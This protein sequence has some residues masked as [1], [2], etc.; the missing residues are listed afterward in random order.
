LATGDT[1]APVKIAARYR[2]ILDAPRG[3]C[4]ARVREVCSELGKSKNTI[5][6]H[7][8]RIA[9]G[10]VT[11]EGLPILRKPGPP[12][13]YG[14]KVTNWMEERILDEWRKTQ[15]KKSCYR[16][17]MAEFARRGDPSPRPSY[18]GVQRLLWRSGIPGVVRRRPNPKIQAADFP[19]GQ[20]TN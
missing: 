17:L 7:I 2:Y 12:K 13:G 19:T 11:L 4:A 1:R 9:H 5:L 3:R 18:W 15:N 14:S 10:Q 20:V 8:N 16:A 6:R